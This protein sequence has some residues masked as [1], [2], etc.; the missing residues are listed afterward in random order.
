MEGGAFP[1]LVSYQL[2]YRPK[3]L[4]SR[5]KSCFFDRYCTNT[6]TWL[7]KVQGST[8]ETNVLPTPQPPHHD[9]DPASTAFLDTSSP[10]VCDDTTVLYLGRAMGFSSFRESFSL[11]GTAPLGPSSRS[12]ATDP[13]QP[14]RLRFHAFSPR[15][16]VSVTEMG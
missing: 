5:S 3:P 10:P 13:Q 1:N 8:V 12:P 2:S 16:L 9:R 11:N 14:P 4:Q 15:P 6:C 7:V